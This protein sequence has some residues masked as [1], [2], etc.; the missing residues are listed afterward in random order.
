MDNINIILEKPVV[1]SNLLSPL[2]QS[3]RALRSAVPRISIAALLLLATFCMTD[4]VLAADYEKPIIYRF[5]AAPSI[6]APGENITLEWNISNAET[7]F[8]NPGGIRLNFGGSPAGLPVINGSTVVL[9]INSTNYTLIAMN[10]IGNDTAS[11]GVIV[12]GIGNPAIVQKT[13]NPVIGYFQASPT[14]ILAGEASMLS[15]SVSDA[16]EV[17]ILGLGKVAMA[18]S[19]AVMPSDTTTY[20]LTARNPEGSITASTIVA[21]QKPKPI[22]PVINYFSANPARIIAGSASTLSWSVLDASNVMIDGIGSVSPSGSISVSP[23]TTTVFT[24]RASNPVGK[25]TSTSQVEVVQKVQPPIINYFHIDKSSIS[26]GDRARL[27]WSVSGASWV[28]ISGIGQVSSSGSMSVRPYAS[29]SY[30]LSASNSGGTRSESVFV[31]VGEISI[32]PID[33]LYPD[34]PGDIPIGIMPI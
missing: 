16:A 27:S 7:L 6:A 22:R 2:H 21:V 11:T 13:G 8:V 4:M 20:I 25:T 14:T 32:Q 30:T 24:L 33:P 17:T 5:I 34:M 15:W 28:T 12:R 26:T 3:I 9:P 31:E 18:G 23:R 19:T 10:G 1:D 29:T